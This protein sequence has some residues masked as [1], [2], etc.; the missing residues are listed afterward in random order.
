MAV[1]L[2]DLTARDGNEPTDGAAL[3]IGMLQR[4]VGGLT[5]QVTELK[6]DIMVVDKKFEHHK[7]EVLAHDPAWMH[8]QGLR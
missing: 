6:A 3:D 1:A 8:G 4:A 5:E 7:R 2:S